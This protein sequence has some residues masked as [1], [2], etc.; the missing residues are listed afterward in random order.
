MADSMVYGNQRLEM[1]VLLNQK[2][3]KWCFMKQEFQKPYIQN[4][5]ES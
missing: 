1:A 3:D 5:T 2:G 4:E